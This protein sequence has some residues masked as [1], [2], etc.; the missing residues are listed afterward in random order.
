[1]G[2]NVKVGGEVRSSDFPTRI[3]RAG[4]SVEA[5]PARRARAERSEAGAVGSAS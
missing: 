3:V 5:T 2:R 4:E 1:V